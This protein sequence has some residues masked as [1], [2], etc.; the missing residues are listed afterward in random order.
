MSNLAAID[1]L[2]A[3][4]PS[5][6]QAEA[7]VPTLSDVQNMGKDEVEK[8]QAAQRMR[9]RLLSVG[10]EIES[11]TKD[12]RNFVRDLDASPLD[13]SQ[14]NAHSA[15]ED[16]EAVTD[17]ALS[18]LTRTNNEFCIVLAFMRRYLRHLNG[19]K[20]RADMVRISELM[21]AFSRTLGIVRKAEHDLG[22]LRNEVRRLV[23]ARPGTTGAFPP[24]P[25]VQVDYDAV[26]DSVMARTTKAR[27][28]LAR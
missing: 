22:H 27:A 20:L 12:L 5:L 25:P 17:R 9:L 23:V 18:F 4:L 21:R 13:A 24:N 3:A 19:L 8:V 11:F 1:R 2:R 28:Y 15:I 26:I 16:I 10:E 7:A 14:Q 6:E